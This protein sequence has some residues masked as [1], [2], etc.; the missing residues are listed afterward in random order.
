VE[1][2]FTF[3]QVAAVYDRARADY[4]DTLFADVSTFAGLTPDDAILELGCS[5]GKATRGFARL[6]NRILALDPG[7]DLIRIARESL[8]EF[9]NVT[10]TAST[11]EAWPPEPTAF[12]LVIAAQSLH[13][14]APELRFGK[15]ADMLVPGGA[16]AVF[17]NVPVGMA[18]S[19][20]ADF[21]RIY[22]QHLGITLGAPPEA[23]YL[24]SGPITTE[25]DASRRFAAVTHKRYP[26]SR[27]F[28]AQGYVDFLRT[29]SDHQLIP[30]EPREAL[31]AAV[32]EAI[33][34]H[35]GR[36]DLQYETHLYMARRLSP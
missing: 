12:R 10:F 25:F 28:S 9:P 7:L 15:A 5:T 18:P 20:L 6:G 29:R 13:W 16:L 24:P 8:A 31:L 17:G 3:N 30:P 21:Q 2:R 36:F 35:G 27:P 26:W 22:K 23:W 33:A 1:Q 19:L 11:F 34:A 4:P 32:A 14:I